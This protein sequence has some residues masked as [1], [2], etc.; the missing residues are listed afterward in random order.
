MLHNIV[1][2]IIG[3]WIEVLGTIVGFIYLYLEYKG[4]IKLWI[5]GIIMPAIYLQIYFD[6]GL[7][8]D[9]AINIYYLVIAIYG[10]LMWK[11]GSLFAFQKQIH[12]SS[13]SQIMI[14]HI[15]KK[16]AVVSMVV[17]LIIWL[18][19]AQILIHFTNSTV[20][21]LDAFTTALSIVGMWLLA[22]KIVEQWWAWLL[23]DIVSAAL[24]VYKELYLTAGLYAV[25]VVIIFFGYKKW[26]AM[27]N[28]QKLE[29]NE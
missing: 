8:A 20:P 16:I 29:L 28:E 19:I 4:S 6:A 9:F 13:N 24:Y 15:S 14:S 12:K 22:H 10:W 5:A 11:Y 1:Q 18:L 2:Y 27:M 26:I 17:F 7:Y 23:V 3:N 25:Y 21:W